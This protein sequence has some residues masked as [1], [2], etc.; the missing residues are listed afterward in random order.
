M[1]H[2]QH[3]KK[4]NVTVKNYV[5]IIQVTMLMLLHV[6][7]GY[8]S[9]TAGWE[10]NYVS[11]LDHKKRSYKKMCYA[12]SWRA[13]LDSSAPGLKLIFIHV[14]ILDRGPRVQVELQEQTMALETRDTNG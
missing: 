11:G 9:T 4:R 5:K 7:F 6:V 8:R 1:V 12:L 10:N 13:S 2:F 14:H 3:N